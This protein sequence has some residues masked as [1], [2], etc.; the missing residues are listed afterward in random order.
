MVETLT[1]CITK[2]KK[3]FRILLGLFMIGFLVIGLQS[4]NL[5]KMAPEPAPAPA[6]APQG[7]VISVTDCNCLD[8]YYEEDNFPT[9][10]AD[11]E[12]KITFFGSVY[13]SGND[14][15][16][17]NSPWYADPFVDA[18]NTFQ[19]ADFYCRDGRVAVYTIETPRHHG[20]IKVIC[21]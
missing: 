17:G 12:M 6:P 18:S 8:F 15:N 11:R 13:S 4:F 7:T 9:L 3:K 19:C 21:L 16:D 10:N 2:M 1:L 5:T 14:Q 20:F